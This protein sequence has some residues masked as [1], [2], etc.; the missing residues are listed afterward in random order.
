MSKEAGYHKWFQ[1]HVWLSVCVPECS[2]VKRPLV[3]A[4]E[5]AVQRTGPYA[6]V[7]ADGIPAHS[8]SPAQGS[9]LPITK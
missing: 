9:S 6:V 2:A 3:S 1:T 4:G 7:P 5:G 8:V